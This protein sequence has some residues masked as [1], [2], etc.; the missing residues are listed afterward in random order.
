M[1]D[2]KTLSHILFCFTFKY[3]RISQK[4]LRIDGNVTRMVICVGRQPNFHWYLYTSFERFWIVKDMKSYNSSYSE[5]SERGK[6]PAVT[7]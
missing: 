4:L 3:F 7:S 5:N 1:C 6:N 2:D